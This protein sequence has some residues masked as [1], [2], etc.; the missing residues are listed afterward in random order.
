M[1]MDVIQLVK[2]SLAT[3]A[4]EVILLSLTFAMRFVE[5]AKTTACG[6]VMM[7]TLS[8]EMGAHLHAWLKEAINAQVEPQPLLMSALKYVEMQ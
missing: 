2:L 8:Q 7:E 6:G 4:M 5:M 1:E 3:N